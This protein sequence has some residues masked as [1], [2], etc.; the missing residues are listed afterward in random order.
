M[1]G[2]EASL[3]APLMFP[4]ASYSPTFRPEVNGELNP[5]PSVAALPPSSPLQL[6]PEEQTKT[7]TQREKTSSRL[8]LIP[9]C[10]DIEAALGLG[11]CLPLLRSWGGGKIGLFFFFF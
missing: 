6:K 9:Q 4:S 1:L 11:L 2:G 7:L 8:E 5:G 3:D 10:G